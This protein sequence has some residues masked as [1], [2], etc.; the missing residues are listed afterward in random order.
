MP[1]TVFFAEYLDTVSHMNGKQ[2]SLMLV[3][4][5]VTGMVGNLLAGKLL[6]NKAI[7]TAIVFQ[8][9]FG[10]NSINVSNMD[11]SRS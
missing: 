2:I 5:G 6:S 4:F 10:V 8:F 9:V 3:L 1:S 11:N 7:T